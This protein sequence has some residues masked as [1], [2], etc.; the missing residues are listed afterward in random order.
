MWSQLISGGLGNQLFMVTA[1]S[2]YVS[3][4]G[5]RGEV[6][7]ARTRANGNFHS[8]QSIDLSAMLG[9]IASQIDLRD[10]TL[11]DRVQMRFVPTRRLYRVKQTGYVS[12]STE[13]AKRR[14]R[15]V[16]AYFQSS[17]YMHSVRRFGATFELLPKSPS[18][19]F[20]RAY[21]Y[22]NSSDLSWVHFRR[23]D[24]ERHRS[25]I[26]L[27]SDK[28]FGTAVERAIQEG[29]TNFIVSSDDREACE[30]L[31]KVLPGGIEYVIVEELGDF[32]SVEILSLASMSGSVIC[33]NSSFGWWAAMGG[34]ESKF[35]IAP[36]PWFAGLPQPLRLFSPSEA[37]RVPATFV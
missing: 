33:S 3:I 24:Y 9:P 23:G 13:L 25:T 34:R 19:D 6:L 35:V 10:V 31:V 16:F 4:S 17:E 26:G 37:V 12:D 15:V 18:S 11:S 20:I 28:Y 14:E 22:F 5:S 29:R 1:A 32:S 27:L 30:Q 2:H 21:D 7:V 36:K 8:I